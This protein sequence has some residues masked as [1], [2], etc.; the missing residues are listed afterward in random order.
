MGDSLEVEG[1]TVPENVTLIEFP[2]FVKYLKRA[3]T[4]WIAEDD[5][6]TIPPALDLALNDP[7]HQEELQ[8]FISDPQV[9]CLFIQRSSSK[10]NFN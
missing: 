8:K 6:D 7:Q 5:F 10:G 2:T 1:P 3:V 9:S 4:I